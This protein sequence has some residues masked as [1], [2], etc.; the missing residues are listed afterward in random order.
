VKRAPVLAGALLAAAST[1]AAGNA[2]GVT[3]AWVRWLP[4]DL[5]EGGY[6][7]ITN[8][9]DNA[10]RLIGADSPDYGMVMLHRSVQRD[11]VE[12]MQT[13]AGIVVPAHG[14][15]ALEP[16]GYHLMLMHP[17]HAIAP[18]GK[19]RVRLHFADGSTINAEFPVRPATAQ[20]D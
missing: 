1:L 6:A 12:T 5:P 16:G 14:S 17:L 2:A 18:G 20:G 10:L 13:V 3:H 9:G 19:V 11:G 15:A 8:S 7:V 4:G